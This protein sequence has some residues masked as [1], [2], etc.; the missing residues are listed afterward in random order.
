M[1]NP[2]TRNASFSHGNDSRTTNGEVKSD[3]VLKFN[4][5]GA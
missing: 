2:R 5:L 3:S 1:V 4:L